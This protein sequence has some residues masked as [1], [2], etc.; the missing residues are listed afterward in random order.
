MADPL[1]IEPRFTELYGAQ[2]A[3]ARRPEYGFYMERVM[4]AESVLDVGTGTG[5]LLHMARDAGHTGRL[6]GIDP[7]EA[8]LQHART[9]SDIEWILGDAASGAWDREFDLIVITGHAFQAIIDDEQIRASL[10]AIQSALTAEG[11]FIVETRNPT[12]RA[13]EQWTPE[14]VA[15]FLDPQG[16]L[17]RTW[18]ENG[19]LEGDLLTVTSKYASD[20][21]GEPRIA[22][23]TLRFL[24][25]ETLAEFLSQA[26]LAIDEQYGD[27]DLQPLTDASPE[28]IT[29]AKRA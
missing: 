23:S 18:Y 16:A 1:F 25:A 6:C 5:E 13:W 3:W 19:V 8:M 22:R 4:A 28:I 11:R 21:W 29:I 26:G 20:S 14:R 10:A 2:C 24:D 7:S 12:V 9:R 27:W 15:E 17:V